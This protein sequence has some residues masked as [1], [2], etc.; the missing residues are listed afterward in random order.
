MTVSVTR[1]YGGDV[2]FQVI[3]RERLFFDLLEQ[4]ADGVAVGA[5]ELVDLVDAL[6]N[7]TEQLQRIRELEHAGDDLTHRIMSTLST[8]F[9]TPFDRQD[10]HKL[11]ST[12]DDVLDAVEA[13][14]DLL[15]LHRVEEPLP[16]LRQQAAVLVQITKAVARE[17]RHL[18]TLSSVERDWS[19][20]NRLERE[21]DHVY[22]RATAD[23]FSGD[24]PAIEV[25]K[26][27]DIVDQVEDAIDR[28]QSI[29]NT[30]ESIA[31]KYA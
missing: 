7:A 31:L 5:R 11:A 1:G 16:A 30:M 8:T 18:R 24:H 4:A 9:V 20:I 17:V 13:V 3:P 25:L 19:D 10:I 26:W 29:S 28:C 2:V 27:K 12:L 15:V 6:P 21:G 22:R 23:L 14:S